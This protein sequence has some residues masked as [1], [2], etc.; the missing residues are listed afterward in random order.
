V[1]SHDGAGLSELH[2][3]V[4]EGGA[5]TTGGGPEG[6][7]PGKRPRLAWTPQLHKRFVDAVSHLGLK[8]AVPKTIMQVRSAGHC[9]VLAVLFPQLVTLF[10]TR[11]C[12]PCCV[13]RSS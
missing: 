5:A 3:G 13:I 12:V 10:M 7:A 6:G 9:C 2:N 11:P 8:T 4:E 1:A